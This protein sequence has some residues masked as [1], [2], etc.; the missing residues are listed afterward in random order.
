[1]R[2]GDGGD[3]LRAGGRAVT[4]KAPISP[5][6]VQDQ[7]NQIL[8][9]PGF[10]GSARLQRFLRLAVERTLAGETNQMKEYNVGRAPAK[11]T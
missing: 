8:A 7:L 3:E 1:M 2:G 11:K 4:A 9:S 6:E 10:R 5:A